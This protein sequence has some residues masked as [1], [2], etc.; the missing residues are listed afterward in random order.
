M[1]GLRAPGPMTGHA[2]KKPRGEA[3]AST[4]HG[5]ERTAGLPRTL[6]ACP[7]WAMGILAVAALMRGVAPAQD[8]EH[9]LAERVATGL[10][11][12]DGITWAREGFLVFADAGKR[13]LYRLDPGGSQP[14]PTEED[15]NGGQ[16]LAYDSQGRLYICEPWTRRVVRMERKGKI[17]P[18]A[19]SFEG[20]KLNGPDDVAVRKDGNVYFTD[21][22]FGSAADTRELDFNGVYHVTPK[23]EIE[24]VAKWKTRPNGIAL[25]PDGKTLYV[26]D[27][28]RHAVVA[29]SLDGRGAATDPRDLITKISGVPNGMR[30]DVT[31]RLYVGAKGLQIYSPEGKLLHTMLSG[32][33]ITNCAFGDNDF[34]TLYASAGKAV[35]KI[36]LGVKGALQY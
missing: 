14:K 20:K 4:P 35:Y 36:R 32:D 30:T 12:A 5:G 8:F 15:P 22:A 10:V 7:T 29:F 26:G 2:G 33:V 19:E 9:I 31:G 1:S 3:E 18:F 13:K 17:E 27:G 25:S 28:D 6:R 16:G 23:G 34:E 21:P 11:Y 24:A